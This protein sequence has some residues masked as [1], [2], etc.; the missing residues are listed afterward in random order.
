[1]KCIVVFDMDGVIFGHRNFWLELHKAWETLEEGNILTKK[2][3]HSDYGR[4]VAE[5]VNRLWE[6][7]PQESY[8]ELVAVQQYVTGAREAVEGI[9]K[10]GYR[11]AIITSGPYNLALRA[12]IELG[13]DDIIANRLIFKNGVHVGTTDMTLWPVQNDEKVLPLQE[14]CKKHNISANNVTAV[15]HDTNDIR[16]AEYV[17]ASGGK[18]IGFMYEPHT[19]VE[20]HCDVVVRE[21]D[22]R[23]ILKYL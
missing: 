18:V 11:T 10:K 23:A 15:I 2:Y 4:L 17:K 20:K 12:Q 21:K 8:D 5:V 16:L 19:E 7:K 1:M 22:L 3:L 14:L 6:G 13:V 9:I